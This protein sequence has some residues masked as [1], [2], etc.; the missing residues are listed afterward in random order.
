MPEA[1][2]RAPLLAAR[3]LRRRFRRTEALQGVDVELRAGESVA[4]LGPNGAG[5]T[6]LLTLL[7][8]ADRPSDGAV[9]GADAAARVGWVPQRPAVYA[10]LSAR[11][12]LRL[13]AGLE[14]ADDPAGVAEALLRR[15]DLEA[16]ADRPAGALST[17]TLQRLNLCVA[18][19]G[20]PT[21]LLLDEPSAT[22]SPDQRVRLWAWL[23]ELR[24]EGALALLFSTQ[25][26]HEAVRHGDRLLVL[27]DGRVVFS[28]DAGALV[29]A[30]GNTPD[31]PD[32]AERAFLR[33]VE[34]G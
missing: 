33:L 18:L 29:A 21:V 25:S 5:K 15:G 13:F 26:V 17:G 31:E 27:A 3:G 22:L 12:N 1:R 20:A 32:A 6:T 2:P 10:R 11:E 28:G 34:P 16:V 23:D 19:A 4:L 8:G 24:R 7:A 14:G 30:G 9:L